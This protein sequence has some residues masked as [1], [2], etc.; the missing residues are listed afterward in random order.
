MTN[1]ILL[2]LSSS[3]LAACSCLRDSSLLAASAT[4]M[5]SSYNTMISCIKKCENVL[6]DVRSKKKTITPI[7]LMKRTNQATEQETH[8]QADMRVL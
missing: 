4:L 1:L 2:S 3:S 8:Q 7:G 6:K 5:S